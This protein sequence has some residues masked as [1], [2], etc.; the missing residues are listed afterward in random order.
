[1]KKNFAFI[2]LLIIISCTKKPI[3]EFSFINNNETTTIKLF[4]DNTFT[5]D[6]RLLERKYTIEGSW[7]GAIEEGDTFYTTIKE[8]IEIKKNSYYI[9]KNKAISFVN[10]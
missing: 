10:E 3:K 5:Q 8:G 7:Q 9:Y 2:I 1:M 4:E 6:N